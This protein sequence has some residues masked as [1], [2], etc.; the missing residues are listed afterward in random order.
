MNTTLIISFLGILA[1]LIP[2][3]A[4]GTT[5]ATIAEIITILE[6][7][8]PLAIQVGEDLVGPVKNI[9]AALQNSGALTP[10]QL[11]ALDTQEA[12]LDAGF[13]AAATAATAA[14]TTASGTTSGTT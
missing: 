10:D 1:K 8:I 6:Q 13:D 12:A 11:D 2:T 3:I 9:I 4:S 14:D 5:A 7:V